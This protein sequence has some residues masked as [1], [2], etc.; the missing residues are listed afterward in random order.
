MPDITAAGQIGLW[1]HRA[2]TAL[3]HLHEIQALGFTWIAPKMWEDGSLY[4]DVAAFKQLVAASATINLPVLVWGYSR[5]QEIDAQIAVVSENLPAGCAGIVIDAEVEWERA[6][7]D[8]LAHQ[9]CHGIA[10]SIGHRCPLHLSTFY[11]PM[12]HPQFP[13]AAF[14]THCASFMPQSYI[15]GQ[16]PAD[17]VVQRTMGQAYTIAKQSGRAL[18]PTVNDPALL[19]FLRN[20]GIRAANVWLWES[21]PGDSDEGVQDHESAWQGPVATFKQ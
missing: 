13:Y 6:G 3:G 21:E 18:V 20:A 11:A 5:P 10:E 8:V 12:L 15:E 1:I 2:E 9:L 14:L 16:A 4:G 17:L 19:P 7:T